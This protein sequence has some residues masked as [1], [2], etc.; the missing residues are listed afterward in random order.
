MA[1]NWTAG[2]NCI[3]QEHTLSPPL[4]KLS[5]HA[6]AASKVLPADPL[7]QPTTLGILS[8]KWIN[9]PCQ[10]VLWIRSPRSCNIRWVRG[11]NRTVGVKW[12]HNRASWQQQCVRLI[13]LSI[14]VPLWEEWYIIW[15]YTLNSWL[16]E[17]YTNNAIMCEAI[18]HLK[19]SFKAHKLAWFFFSPT[20]TASSSGV[21]NRQKTWTY[22]SKFTKTN[23]GMEHLSYEERLRARAVQWGEQKTPGRSYS[24]LSALLR[25]L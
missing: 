9:K 15:S 7:G 22:W 25:V 23:G 16:Y 14:P 3:L 8:T 11:R 12:E 19:T 6:D 2:Y 1:T 24:T 21:L 5:T 17:L 10:P 13:H 20:K 18:F 4:S